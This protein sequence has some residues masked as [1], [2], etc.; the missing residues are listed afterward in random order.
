MDPGQRLVDHLYTS[1]SID[2]EWAAREPRGFT[3]WG[4]PCAQRI[5]AEEAY[6]D[7]GVVISRVHA[8]TDLV[9]I[10]EP[11]EKILRVLSATANFATMSG[12]TIEDGAVQSR[13]SVW[14]HEGTLEMWKHIF[15][16]AAAVQNASAQIEAKALAVAL[17]C[18][19]ALSAHPDSG[20][21]DDLDDMLN[22]IEAVIAPMGR[23][24]SKF[25][26]PDFT[27][28]ERVAGPRVSVLTTASDDGLTSELAFGNDTSMLL[29]MTDQPNPRLGSGLLSVLTLPIRLPEAEIPKRIFELNRLEV[30]ELNHAPFLGSWCKHPSLDGLIAH[31]SFLPNVCALPNLPMQLLMYAAARN[32]WAAGILSAS[33]PQG[34]PSEPPKSAITRF[35]DRFKM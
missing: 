33:E 22:V 23:G 35:F 19:P 25:I 9:R 30:E 8:S 18:Q 7:K 26:G 13:A 24:T 15:A 1:F 20:I 34:P 4:G 2:A 3:W 12:F 29:M 21:R 32:Q 6:D 31:V 28:A 14:V 5:W 11:T 10:V 16:V 17:G 27:A